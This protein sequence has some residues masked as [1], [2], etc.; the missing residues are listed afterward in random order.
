MAR[1][2]ASKRH[3]VRVP[4]GELDVEE[5]GR[6]EPLVLLQGLGQ[7]RWAWR[8]VLPQL[9]ERFRTIT[10]DTRGTGESF[11]PAAPYAVD[12]LAADALAVMTALAVERADVVGFSMGGYVALTLALDSPGAVRSLV[13]AGTGAGGPRR[14][15]RPAHVRAAFD[16]AMGLEPGEFGRRTMPYTFS[17]GWPERDPE[18]FAEILAARLER[19]TPYETLVA[20]AEACYGFYAAG[21]EVERVEAPAL[22]LHG[23][24]DLIVPV[25]NGRMLAARLPDAAYVE[26]PGRGHNLML[27]D[28]ESFASL[29]LDFLERR[30]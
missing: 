29:A 19:P 12:D 6:G 7:G 9:A 14:V 21:R 22:V 8:Y 18:R 10:V 11:S 13:L 23:D 3:R 4:G 2:A 1:V 17:P 24:A 27:E 5:H 30:P 26:L 28:P 16:E 25:E 20:H 15:P